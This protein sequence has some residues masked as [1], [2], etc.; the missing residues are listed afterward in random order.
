MV[1]YVC[2]AKI[3]HIGFTIILKQVGI[4]TLCGRL[5]FE[6]WYYVGSQFAMRKTHTNLHCNDILAQVELSRLET[7]I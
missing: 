7:Q 4:F 2:V 1:L 3:L 5:N 6:L